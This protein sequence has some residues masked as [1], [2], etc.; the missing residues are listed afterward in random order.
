VD[1]QPICDSSADDFDHLVA[2]L[3][4]VCAS[5]EQR[6]GTVGVSVEPV[7]GDEGAGAAKRKVGMLGVQL[8]RRPMASNLVWQGNKER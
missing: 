7:L 4:S 1:V 3:K 2:V 6:S 5:D 8:K